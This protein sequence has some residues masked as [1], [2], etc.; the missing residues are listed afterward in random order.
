MKKSKIFTHGAFFLL[1]VLF[2]FGQLQRI[3]LTN[4]SAVYLHEILLLL[5]CISALIFNQ[6][7]KQNI[8]AQCKKI[9]KI[10]FL[11]SAWSLAGLLFAFALH[12]NVQHA[13]LYGVRIFLYVWFFL[14]LKSSSA[15]R[16]ISQKTVLLGALFSGFMIVL[17][18]FLQYFF[19]PDTRFLFFLGWDDHYYR[20]ISTL[21]DPSFTGLLLCLLFFAVHMIPR[22]ENTLRQQWLF[23]MKT[24]GSFL[25]LFAL[26]LTYSRASFLA[27]GIS[28]LGVLL[29]FFIKKNWKEA[30]L[31][32]FYLLFLVGTIPLLP[33][34]GGE[35]VR[36]E[37]TST[38]IARTS[39]LTEELSLLHNADWLI[40]KGMFVSPFPQDTPF[41]T[42]F[43]VPSHGNVPDNW[44]I[45]I[46]LGSG[47]VGLALFSGVLLEIFKILLRTN[48][49]VFVSLVTILI[50]GLF[51]AGVFYPFTMVFFSL[52]VISSSL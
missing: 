29:S 3:Q 40:G 25:I 6:Q 18:G 22:S 20:L 48:I 36:L 46:L 38:V 11:F 24:G 35:G 8:C 43:E 41:R 51:S 31:F 13:L 50:S 39:S 26:A 2:A 10:F 21:L 9:P 37:R 23:A 49:W 17:F 7:L 47:V 30:V 28:I 16:L 4:H 12:H 52:M 34:R 27:L 45:L 1:C 32:L 5:W 14:T 19:L 33:R 15:L 42:Q 44:I